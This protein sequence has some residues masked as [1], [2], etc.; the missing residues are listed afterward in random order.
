M[1]KAPTDDEL[2]AFAAAAKG[3][4]YAFT[5]F[6]MRIWNRCVFGHIH[7]MRGGQSWELNKHGVADVILKNLWDTG[8]SRLIRLVG[9]EKTPSVKAYRNDEK[10]RSKDFEKRED[11]AI[12]FNLLDA[13]SAVDRYFDPSIEE[14]AIWPW[15]AR[16]YRNIHLWAAR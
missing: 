10:A 9:V 8:N 14:T 11:V 4:Y 15:A 3:P 16:G 1:I 6:D 5:S 13:V 12:R 2:R 7:A